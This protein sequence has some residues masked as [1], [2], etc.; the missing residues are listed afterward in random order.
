MSFYDK[1]YRV[2]KCIPRGKVASY[3][4]VARLCLSPMAAR[5]VGYALHA[6]PEPGVIP[7]HRVVNKEGRLAPQFAFGGLNEQKNLLLGEGVALQ[8]DSVDMSIYAWKPSLEELIQL[9][10]SNMK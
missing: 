7:C 9:D 3:G 6:N 4:Q 8:E 2:V 1:V 5:A 10:T